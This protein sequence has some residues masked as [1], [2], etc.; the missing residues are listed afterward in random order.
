[1]RLI[2]GVVEPEALGDL[3]IARVAQHGVAAADQHGHVG[4][5]DMK[6]IEQLL[7]LGVAIEI[8]VRVRMAVARQELLHPQ[9]AGAMRRA[10]H[11]DVAEAARDQLD[12]AQDERP[13]EDLAQLGVGLHQREQLLAI[14]FDHLA[15]LGDV[16]PH[17]RR[18]GR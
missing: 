7:R 8:D 14:E 2:D 15:G 12:A 5:A 3:L 16:R 10:D 11:D 6:P 9:R 17:Q 4:G 13:H 18:G 1:M